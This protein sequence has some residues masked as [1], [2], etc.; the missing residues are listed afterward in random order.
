MEIGTIQFILSR[1]D[2]LIPTGMTVKG[3]MIL[4]EIYKDE[5]RRISHYND[6]INGKIPS[7]SAYISRF[8]KEGLLI[9]A[10]DVTS[11]RGTAKLV[12]LSPKGRKALSEVFANIES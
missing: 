5:G 9:K 11:T 4:I 12:V 3:A 10:E 8:E 1:L 7:T 6:L 2:P